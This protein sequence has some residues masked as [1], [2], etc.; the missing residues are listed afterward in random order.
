MPQSNKDKFLQE[1]FSMDHQ[2][3]KGE[4]RNSRD[5]WT[6]RVSKTEMTG[7]EQDFGRILLAAESTAKSQGLHCKHVRHSTR[8]DLDPSELT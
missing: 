1:L 5:Q 8:A 4:G 3:W 2:E 6:L 7:E